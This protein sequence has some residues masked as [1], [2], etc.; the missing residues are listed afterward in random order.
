MREG[1]LGLMRLG[2]VSSVGFGGEDGWA[3]FEMAEDAFSTGLCHTP[4]ANPQVPYLTWAEVAG[5]GHSARIF[6][7]FFHLQRPPK[8]FPLLESRAEC[9]CA[10]S[11]VHMGILANAMGQ[12]MGI[13]NLHAHGRLRFA[14]LR[15]QTPPRCPPRGVRT[16]SVYLG[17]LAAWYVPRG[18]RHLASGK[19]RSD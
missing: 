14:S 7:S 5:E 13:C 1:V 4:V 15:L 12:G 11:T 19:I 3:C 2:C 9:W 18:L 8:Q 17:S 16:Y 10:V 6:Q